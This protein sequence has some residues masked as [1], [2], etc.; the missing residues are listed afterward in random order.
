MTET[1]NQTA[2]WLAGRGKDYLAKAASEGRITMMTAFASALDP[3]PLHAR[4]A[5]LDAALSQAI[6]NKESGDE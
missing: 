3:R 4:L 5:E 6:G 2:V 1:I